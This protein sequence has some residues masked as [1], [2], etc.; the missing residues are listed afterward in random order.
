MCSGLAVRRD[1]MS[2]HT[3][4]TMSDN[5]NKRPRNMDSGDAA[6]DAVA[7]ALDRE[8]HGQTHVMGTSNRGDVYVHAIR[9]EHSAQLER[10][11]FFRIEAMSFRDL[12]QKNLNARERHIDVH[13]DALPLPNFARCQER[14]RFI[15]LAWMSVR[16]AV[17]DDELGV[18]NRDLAARS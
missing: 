16:L 14:R 15:G 18:Q 6:S 8:R 13:S 10:K 7:S 5:S 4:A 1:P 12:S 9:R 11:R 3:L 2:V 17:A